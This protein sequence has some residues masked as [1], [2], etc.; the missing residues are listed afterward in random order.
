MAGLINLHINYQYYFVSRS[1]LSCSSENEI[2]FSKNDSAVSLLNTNQFQI[3]S[4][5]N[6]AKKHPK[7]RFSNFACILLKNEEMQCKTRKGKGTA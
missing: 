5:F 1:P 7:L 4:Y 6:Y 3:C 2:S